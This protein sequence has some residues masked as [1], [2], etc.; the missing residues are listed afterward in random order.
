MSAQLTLLVF[1]KDRAE[2]TKRLC[3]Y[4]SEIH[5]PY[6]VY[7]ADGSLADDN[8]DYLGSNRQ[9][10]FSY[11]YKRFS[12]DLSL[13]DYYQK[14]YQALCDVKT[15][16]VM[17]ADNDDFPIPEGQSKAIQ[18]LENNSKFIGCN[19]QIA[20]ISLSPTAS[21]PYG[22]NFLFHQYYCQTMDLPVKLDQA[23]ATN[24]IESY[25]SNFYS[26]FYS[27]FRTESLVCTYSLIKDLDFSDLG[28]HELFFS[29]MQLAQGKVH[30]I[31]VITYIRQK[32]SSQT[33][34]VQKDWFH[35][36]FYTN[37]LE[38]S[39]KAIH[40]IAEYIAINEKINVTDCYKTLYE[41]FVKRMRDRYIPNDF[42]LLKNCCFSKIKNYIFNV[43]TGKLFS[44]APSV[45]ERLT[46]NMSKQVANAARVPQR[47]N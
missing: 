33:A 40:T 46:K 16:Y 28:I 14:C 12:K 3:E 7:F 41:L 26:I 23:L 4:L 34:A 6:P 25:L 5:Y 24:R 15:P 1:L 19:G 11:T 21:K 10:S 32:G 2:F 36:L 20:G 27:I 35:R 42:Y 9:F 45:T 18:F 47:D 38:D 44:V 31:D 17:I 29:Y 37:W 22:K 39:Q 43:L 30:S 8:E 13:S